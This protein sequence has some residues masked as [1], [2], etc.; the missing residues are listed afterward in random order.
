MSENH[1]GTAAPTLLERDAGLLWHPY[2]SLVAGALYSVTGAAGSQLELAGPGGSH[3]VID[4][5][6][7]WWSAVH[8]YNH[9]TL[10]A[11]AH[12]QIEDY[13]HV[14]FG[15]LTHAPAVELAERLRAAA[16]PGLE[17]VFL[18]DSGSVS[19][20]VALKTAVQ[21]QGAR[22]R[23][24]RHRFLALRGGYHGDTL[25][26]MG[27]C[28][29]VDGMHSAFPGLVAGH[30]FASR[31]PPARFEPDAGN[32]EGGLWAYDTEA[33][34]AWEGQVRRQVAE[35]TDTLAGIVVEPVLQGAGGMY[36]YP[37]QV[38]RILRAIADEEDL[39]FILDEIATGFGRTGKYFAGEWAGVVPDL[40]CVGKALT[41]GYVTLAALLVGQRVARVIAASD[42]DTILHGPTF[43]GNPLAC[44]IAAASMDLLAIPDAGGAPAWKTA[45]TALQTGLHTGLQPAME[46]ACVSDVRVL[47]G[48]GV[49]ALD[50][51]VD[52]TALT[53]AAVRAGAWVRPFR[54]LVY[55]MPPYVAEPEELSRL[56]SAVTGAIAEV[57][58]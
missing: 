6:S 43:M 21:Y 42:T 47:G 31:P 55:L 45:V 53:H 17:H 54:N 30:L 9:P 41:G 15:G 52:V 1:T 2:A 16:P 3:R 14:M 56:C 46:L 23:A 12:A 58:A 35:T 26:A 36:V 7:S 40:M 34:E 18:A 51:P 27:V 4:G 8:G 37:P 24:G 19:I 11:A 49:I 38:L 39:V 33:L 57:H 48:I 10:N 50:R 20:E 5:M 25:G 22:R 44:R 32:A 28:D 13:S 29:P